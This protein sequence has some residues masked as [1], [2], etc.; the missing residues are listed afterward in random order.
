MVSWCLLLGYQIAVPG[1]PLLFQGGEFGQGREFDWQSPVAWNESVEPDR[2]G[3]TAFLVDTK[4]PGIE[5]RKIE[6]LGQRGALR[7]IRAQHG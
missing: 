7:I 4:L 5:V 2:Q 6:T 1:R 3:I